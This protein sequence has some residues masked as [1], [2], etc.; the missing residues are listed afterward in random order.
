MDKSSSLTSCWA[1]S[2]LLIK[3]SQD[4][5]RPKQHNRHIF[6]ITALR[7][8]LKLRY[9][10]ETRGGHNG[11]PPGARRCGFWRAPPERPGY[12]D[13]V[14]IGFH[15]NGARPRGPCNIRR[16]IGIPADR[17]SGSLDFPTKPWYTVPWPVWY[18]PLNGNAPQVR[19]FPVEGHP[20]PR[21]PFG[22]PME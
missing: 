7:I 6:R 2:S 15:N 20:S 16:P 12:R 22:C 14:P 11:F 19:I 4:T 10:K 3:S 17:A 8:W 21:C 9:F 1:F 13:K 18:F 5:S